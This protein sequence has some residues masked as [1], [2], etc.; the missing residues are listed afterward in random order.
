MHQDETSH[1]GRLDGDPAPHFWAHVRCD[2]MAGSIK[3]SLSME[4]G[5]GPG[6]FV[7]EEGTVPQFSVHVYCAQTAGWIWIKMPLGTTHIMLDGNSATPP[8]TGAQHPTFQ[9]MS[10]VAKRLHR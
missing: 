10:I 1:A 7:L 5:L 6:D 4:V 3:M 8:L 2:Q 9:P